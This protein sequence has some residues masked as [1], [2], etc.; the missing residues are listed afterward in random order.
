MECRRNKE[1]EQKHACILRRSVSTVSAVAIHLSVC[2]RQSFASN[3]LGPKREHSA[4][5][6]PCDAVSNG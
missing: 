4:D 1:R 5:W 2:A 3:S 6:W